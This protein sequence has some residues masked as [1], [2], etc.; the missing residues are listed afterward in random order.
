[1]EWQTLTIAALGATFGI[2]TTLLNDL[3]RSRRDGDEQ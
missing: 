2:G 3:V 1:M